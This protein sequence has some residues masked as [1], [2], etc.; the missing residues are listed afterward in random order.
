MLP[1]AIPLL[2]PCQEYIVYFPVAKPFVTF[3]P[4]RGFVHLNVTPPEKESDSL[5]FGFFA[6]LFFQVLPERWVFTCPFEY[7]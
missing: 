2:R 7:K 6:D 3:F 5:Y 4:Q 1:K